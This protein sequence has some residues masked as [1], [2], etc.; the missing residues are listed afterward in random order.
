MAHRIVSAAADY[1]VTSNDRNVASLAVTSIN[2][3]NGAT[4]QDGGGNNLD[5]TSLSAVPSYSGPQIDTSIPT[6]TAVTET[7]PTG[8][9]K[10][11]NKVTI[12]LTTSEAVTVSGS[13][14]LALNDNGIATYS[15]I[16]TDGKTLTFAYTVATADIDV[17]SLQV[18]SI[19]L[20]GGATIRDGG[21][22]NLDLTSYHP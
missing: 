13:P 20:P 6:L 10:A 16:S 22:N 3:P 5:L 19:N 7:P 18:S 21:G 9:F 15:G 14:T 8:D 17:A 11:G 12:T 2:L 4:I 1:T